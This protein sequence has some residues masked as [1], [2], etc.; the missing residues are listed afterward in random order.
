MTERRG[1]TLRRFISLIAPQGL[2]NPLQNHLTASDSASIRASCSAMASVGFEMLV[3][4]FG[5]G[6]DVENAD[7]AYRARIA[8][9]IAFC[10]ALGIEVG[11]YDLIGWSG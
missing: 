10:R 11:G 5:S 1:L 6:F 7:P 9:D 4:S 3:L 2:E 8:A